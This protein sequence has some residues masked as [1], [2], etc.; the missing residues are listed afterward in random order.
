[1]G[2]KSY[3]VYIL[4]NKRYGTLYVGVTNNIHRRIWEHKQKVNPGFSQR[5]SLSK[6]VYY[7]EFDHIDEAIHREKCIKKWNRQWKIDLIETINPYWDDLFSE[8]IFMF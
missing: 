2:K 7:E 3:F 8:F 4:A 1:M 6:L 5:Y